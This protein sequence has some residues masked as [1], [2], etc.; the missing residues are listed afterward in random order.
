MKRLAF[1]FPGQGAR[2][3]LS[4]LEFAESFPEG[5]RLLAHARSLTRSAGPLEARGGQIL[6]RTE[7]LQPVL[8]AISLAMQESLRLHDVHPAVCLGHSLGELSALAAS[9]VISSIE[10]IELAAER[11]RCMAKAASINPGGLAV[12]ESREKVDQAIRES[13]SLQL[14]LIN[15]PDEFVL[16]GPEAAV[17][18]LGTRRVPVSGPWH[19][20]AMQPAAAAWSESLAAISPRPERVPVL[21]PWDALS[22]RLT[23]T[24]DFPE[25]LCRVPSVDG[26][27]TVGPGLVLRGLLRRNLGASIPVWTAERPSDIDRLSDIVRSAS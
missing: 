7:V 14:A 27:V 24:F 25:L 6:E 18:A 17:R 5:A 23:T 16:G 1:V 2:E 3:L 13:P 15:A 10:A 21:T 8:V 11:G 9:G 4:A 19:T 26:Y 22:S 12:V 20:V